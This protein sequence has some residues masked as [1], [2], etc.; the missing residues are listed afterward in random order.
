MSR[1]PSTSPASFRSFDSVIGSL[2][3]LFRVCAGQHL[4]HLVHR[5]RPTS[6]DALCPSLNRTLAPVLVGR[7]PLAVLVQ[8]KRHEAE[9]LSVDAR[10]FD[11]P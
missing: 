7:V 11:V 5:P 10:T 4:L 3:Q 8:A 2:S 9:A 6:D 1:A